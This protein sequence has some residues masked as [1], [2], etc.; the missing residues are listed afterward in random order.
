VLVTFRGGFVAD[1]AIVSRLLDLEARGCT[2]SLQADGRFRVRPPEQLTTDDV[3]F[4]RGHR[5]AVRSVLEYMTQEH[6]Q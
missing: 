5:D 2:F 4:L 6:T 1:W 3:A